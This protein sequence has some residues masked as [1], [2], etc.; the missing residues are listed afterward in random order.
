MKGRNGHGWRNCSGAIYVTIQ[1]RS[2]HRRHNERDGAS[3]HRRLHC[4]LNCWFRRRSKKTSKLCATGFCVGNSPVTGE[5]PA[6]KASNTEKCFHLMTSSC[7]FSLHNYEPQWNSSGWMSVR[8]WFW[9]NLWHIVN[10]NMARWITHQEWFK[11]SLWRNLWD[12]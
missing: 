10:V 7:D 11:K 12:S 8:N 2:L 1:I 9:H 6:Q 4:L 3:N 5:F